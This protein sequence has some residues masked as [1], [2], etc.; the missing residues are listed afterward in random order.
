MASAEMKICLAAIFLTFGLGAVRMEGDEGVLGLF[1]TVVEDV[2]VV[3]D[4]FVPLARECET[5]AQEPR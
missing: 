4:G 1:G 3:G 2:E 5:E